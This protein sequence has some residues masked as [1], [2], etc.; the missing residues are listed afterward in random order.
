[1]YQKKS[2][3][4]SASNH[5][6]FLCKTRRS[7]SQAIQPRSRSSD[8]KFIRRRPTIPGSIQRKIYQFNQR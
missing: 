6:P 1:M 8:Q 3:T 5:P 4:K 7:F 2:N